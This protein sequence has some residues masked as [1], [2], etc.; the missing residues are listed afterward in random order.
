MGGQFRPPKLSLEGKGQLHTPKL[1]LADKGGPLVTLTLLLHFF[2]GC[3]FPQSFSSAGTF[4]VRNP[5][6]FFLEDEGSAAL[7]SHGTL[8]G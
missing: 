7:R 1:S 3:G 6:Y 2:L 8:V 4:S 5:I